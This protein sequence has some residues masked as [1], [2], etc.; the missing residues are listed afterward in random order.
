MLRGVDE[1]PEKLVD[2]GMTFEGGCDTVEAGGSR[3]LG[4]SPGIR[5]GAATTMLDGRCA[6]SDAEML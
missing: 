1:T 4:L 5:L 2:L 6:I 3:L